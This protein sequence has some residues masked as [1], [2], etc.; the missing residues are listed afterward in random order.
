MDL[1]L[2]TGGMIHIALNKVWKTTVERYC[3]THADNPIV[4]VRMTQSEYM[5]I[6]GQMNELGLLWMDGA[7]HE[8]LTFY[9]IPFEIVDDGSDDLPARGAQGTREEG[10]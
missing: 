5:F 10:E 9:G 7:G 4:Q 2:S 3:Y 6:K 8:F 1:I